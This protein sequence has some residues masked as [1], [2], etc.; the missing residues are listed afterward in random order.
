MDN[1]WQSKMRLAAFKNSIWQIFTPP[2][3]LKDSSLL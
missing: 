3:P 2:P 1:D